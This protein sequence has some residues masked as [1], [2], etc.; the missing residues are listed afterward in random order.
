M[1]TTAS[2][3]SRESGAAA[4]SRW[5]MSHL[6]LIPLGAHPSRTGHPPGPWA[7]THGSRSTLF[8]AVSASLVSKP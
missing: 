8:L 4:S 1:V 3:A 2:W 7:I 5:V 6:R